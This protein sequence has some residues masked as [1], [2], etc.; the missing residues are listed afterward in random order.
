MILSIF[1][2][3]FLA[4]TT[5]SFPNKNGL[6]EFYA[7]VDKFGLLFSEMLNVFHYPLVIIFAP[8][9]VIV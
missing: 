7:N 9:K 6:L 2:I 8:Q 1:L 3:L 4:D 5:N